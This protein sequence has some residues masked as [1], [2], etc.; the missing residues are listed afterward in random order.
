MRRKEKR[1]SLDNKNPKAQVSA[2]AVQLVCNVSA[3]HPRADHHDI[4]RIAPVA[5][6]FGPRATH[7]P[8]EYIVRKGGLLDIDLIIRIRIQL[9]QNERLLLV[10]WDCGET[11]P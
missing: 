1:A 6:H 7:P 8:T 11:R 2:A 4:E 9:W 3:E 5:T 10:V